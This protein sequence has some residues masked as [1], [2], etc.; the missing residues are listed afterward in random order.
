MVAAGNG[1]A[2]TGGIVQYGHRHGADAAEAQVGG[3]RAPSAAHGDEPLVAAHLTYHICNDIVIP[4]ISKSCKVCV[5][6][7]VC[8]KRGD[9]STWQ[10]GVQG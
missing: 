4:M 10:R 2:Q 6:C 9:R 3:G 1:N 8:T 5:Y 7:N